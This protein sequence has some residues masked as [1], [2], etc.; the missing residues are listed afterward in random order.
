MPN[1][2]LKKTCAALFLVIL[3]IHPAWS[4]S[5]DSPGMSITGAPFAKATD[6]GYEFFRFPEELLSISKVKLAFDPKKARTTSGVSLHFKLKGEGLKATF[7]TRPKEENRG[8]GFAIYENGKLIDSMEFKKKDNIIE[9]E[10]KGKND[11]NFHHYRITLPSW[12]NPIL[13][14]I[15][16]VENSEIDPNYQNEKSYMI[17]IGDSI[18]HGVGQKSFTHLTYPYQVSQN[19]D[20]NLWNVAVGGGKIS[21][22]VAE[23]LAQGPKASHVTLLI[24]YNDWNF[25][26]KTA[27][28]YQQ[29]L[30]QF[31]KTALK[32][33]DQAQFWIMRP[34]FTKT[35]ASKKSGL[36]L[37]VIRDAVDAAILEIN[38]PRC[39]I[40][41]SDKFSDAS[42]L[43]EDT[44]KDP[45]HLGM[46][47]AKMLAQKITPIIKG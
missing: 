45:V 46:K 21:Q 11:G 17:A 16:L 3:Y 44:D 29:D 38:D 24:G 2:Y 25:M 9:L 4:I 18:T 26:G 19:L 7:G 43:R 12:S 40:I 41:E 6:D 36:P 20:L 30:V 14:K 28:V 13:K 8:S 15:E 34:L 10:I 1:R 39:H 23:L 37:Q 32:H 35:K 47:G 31:L 42:Y 27:E 22:P 5:I 33:Q